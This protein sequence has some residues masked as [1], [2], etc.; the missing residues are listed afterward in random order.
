MEFA[1]RIPTKIAL[2]CALIF[3]GLPDLRLDRSPSRPLHSRMLK[4]VASFTP[5]A[6]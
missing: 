3:T 4:G 2:R 5:L 1:D 6:L